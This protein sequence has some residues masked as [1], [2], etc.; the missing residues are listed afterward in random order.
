MFARPHG[1]AM[2]TPRRALVIGGGIAGPAVALFL[3]RAG[4]EPIVFEAYPRRDEVGGGFQI[5]PNGMRVMAALGLADRLLAAGTRSADMVFRNHRGRQIGLVRTHAAG[6]AVNLTRA[7]VIS[8]LRDECER[9]GVAVHYERR[10]V[11]LASVGGET[12]ARFDDGTTESGDFAIGADGVHSRVRNWM[13]P[14][15]GDAQLPRDTQM[16]AIGGY[17]D[18]AMKP[19]ADL[20]DADR[21]AFVIGPR[22]QLGFSRFGDGRWGWWCHAH[23]ATPAERTALLEMPLEQLREAMLARYAGWADPVERLIRATRE[24]SRVPI[25]DVPP[26][27]SWRKANVLLVGDA[28][29]AMS[30]AGGQGASMALEDAMVLGTLLAKPD[31]R[32]DHAMTAFEQLRR[33]RVEPMIAQAYENDRRTLAKLGPIARWARDHVLM[34]RIAGHIGKALDG[35]YAYDARTVA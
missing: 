31:A 25:Y 30:P 19:P 22:H 3:A 13:L 10:L 9:L 6:S 28:A 20:R 7:T 26:L 8:A 4:I 27:A 32:V 21:L 1:L 2:T 5:A 11:D 29:H 12:V 18:R 15:V 23:A 17:C 14:D 33:P 16:I 24:W 34:P 35:V